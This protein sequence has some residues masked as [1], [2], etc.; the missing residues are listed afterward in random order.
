MTNQES[1]HTRTGV[2]T[3][4]VTRV[5]GSVVFATGFETLAKNTLVKI[6]KERILGEIVQVQ[7]DEAVI[8]SYEETTGI[9]VGDPVENTGRP[10]YATLGPGLLGRVYDGMQRSLDTL[11]EKQGAFIQRGTETDVIYQD[12]TF[13]FTPTV[14]AGD[15]VSQGLEIGFVKEKR[16]RHPILIPRGRRPVKV[17]T[18]VPEGTYGVNDKLATLEDGREIGFH[19]HWE[20]RVQ[21]PFA[22]RL[23]ADGPFVTGQRVLDSLFPVVKGGNAIVSGGFGTGKTVLEQCLAKHSRVDVIVLVLIGERGNEVATVLGEFAELKDADG[24]PL[25][26]RTV[27]IVNTSNMPVAAREASIFLGMTV[28]EYYKDLG[29]DVAVLADSTSRWAEALREISGRLQE[30]PGEEGYPSYMPKQLGEFFE[31][32]GK[33]EVFNK[34]IG[35]VTF[36][37]AISPPGG[38]FT[39]PVTQAALRVGGTFWALNTELARSR[40]FPSVDWRMSYSLYGNL[41]AEKVAEEHPRWGIIRNEFLALFKQE[42]ELE[43]NVRLLGRDSLTELQ[44]GILDMAQFLK[45]SFLQQDAFDAVDQD[46]SL[47]K[48]ALMLDALFL[49]WTW[50]KADIKRGILSEEFFEK[51]DVRKVMRIREIPESELDRLTGIIEELRTNMEVDEQ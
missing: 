23:E 45:R 31:R 27:V 14:K 12:A 28:G 16:F 30:M 25:L 15:S 10:F 11:I 21:R 17:A 39:E 35:S 29:L 20:V 34:A 7:E 22:K 5:S 41:I 49:L 50:L 36:I 37:A 51:P 13:D 3:G 40:H 48:Q 47:N 32:A 18:I 4:H 26:D 46:C 2:Q 38:D 8:Q 1:A 44:R 6:S 42:E 9:R 33:F 43:R 24:T 19:Q